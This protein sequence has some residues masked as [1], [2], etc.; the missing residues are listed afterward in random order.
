MQRL[1]ISLLALALATSLSLSGIA[2]TSGDAKTSVSNNTSS[3]EASANNKFGLYYWYTYPDDSYFD[4][5]TLSMEETEWWIMLNYVQV[6]TN[7]SGGTL[8]ARG[9]GTNNYP[10]AAPPLYYL[11]AHYGF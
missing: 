4:R 6:D 8:V 7:P 1:S 10:H 2:K 11:Y 5:Q 3:N 9:Y